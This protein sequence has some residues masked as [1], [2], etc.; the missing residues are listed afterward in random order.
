M[1]EKRLQIELL[2]QYEHRIIW[3]MN[4]QCNMACD[5]C[6]F[7]SDLNKQ[8]KIF[9]P[10]QIYQGFEKTGK[11]WLVLL[12]GGEPLIYPK[13]V[14]IAEILTKKNSI[15]VSTN[16]LSDKIYEFAEKISP[17]QVMAISASL[18]ILEREKHK[19]GIDEFIKKCLLLQEKGFTV[20]VNYVT[21]PPLFKRMENDFEML[22]K[23]GIHQATVLT[24][25]GHFE[26]K[27]YPAAYTGAQ[28][29]LINK[30]AL[31]ET[32]M[33]ISECK[34]NF[35]GYLCE[36]GHKYFSM[37]ENGDITRCGTLHKKYG[38]LFTGTFK[39]DITD[40]PCVADECIDCYLGIISQKN[41]RAT[42]SRFFQE[43]IRNRI[44]TNK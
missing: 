33:L 41:I 29:K 43:K 2:K 34:T 9:S 36:A 13:F 32:E 3:N 44:K 1:P 39:P 19:K 27:F 20:L 16:L 25:R 4:L 38:N 12:S 28:L 42:R 21:W 31:D 17:K 11:E 15:Q 22:R 5:Y 40:K 23:A 7:Y 10:E 24:Y 8:N 18:H 26:N 14:E 30:F 35:S 37:N 6:Y